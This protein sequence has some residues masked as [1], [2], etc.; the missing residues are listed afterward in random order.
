[1]PLKS[2]GEISDMFGSVQ[3]NVHRGE[4]QTALLKLYRGKVYTGYSMDRYEEDNDGITV[5]FKNGE[6][7]RGSALVGADGAQ[8]PVRRCMHPMHKLRYSG[9][10]CWRGLTSSKKIENLGILP[11]GS[12]IFCV[13]DLFSPLFWVLIG[14]FGS[15]VNVKDCCS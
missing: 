4:L 5:Y 10:T 7:V 6:K 12:R 15:R 14:E 13:I 1:V 11:S 9:Y 3:V 2:D 8:S